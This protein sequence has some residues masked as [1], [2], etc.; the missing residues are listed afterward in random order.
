MAE[1]NEKLS[2]LFAELKINPKTSSHEAAF[3]VEEQAQFVGSIPGTLTK[4][5]F[6][7]DKKHG[8]FL[9]TVLADRDV[10]MKDFA[11]LMNLSGANVRFG[12]EDLLKEKLAVIRG[13]VSP[14]ALVNDSAA[15]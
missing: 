1:E 3:T 14:F 13:A 2:S 9:L 15:E 7:R 11:S 8:L 10:N 5:L 4:N 12:D 6:L